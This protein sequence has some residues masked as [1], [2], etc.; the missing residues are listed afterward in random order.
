M[1]NIT[2]GFG[3]KSDKEFIRFLEIAQSSAMEV[4]SITYVLEDLN[5]IPLDQIEL[6]RSKSE[7]TKSLALGLIRHLKS[8][9]SPKT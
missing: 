7:E 2:E 5:Y 9:D 3:R 6:L 1:N 4:R 8:K